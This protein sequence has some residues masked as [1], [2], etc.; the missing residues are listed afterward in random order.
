M[1]TPS[2][3]GRHP[4]EGRTHPRRQVFGHNGV[5]DGKALYRQV[6]ALKDGLSARAD[7]F[8]VAAPLLHAQ[9]AWLMHPQELSER[10]ASLTTDL[11]QLRW[12]SFHRSVGLPSPDP[13]Q[14]HADDP[15]FA[16]PVW[17]ESPTW[18]LVKVTPWINKFYVLDLHPKKSMVRYLLDQ[19]VDVFITSWKNPDESM[20]AV[21]FDDYIRDGVDAIVRVARDFSGA[22]K[23]H[24]VGY[25]IGGTALAIYMAWAARHFGE[26]AVPVRDW[27]LLTTLVDFHTPGD[28]EAF[29]DEGSVAHLTAQMQRKGYLDGKDMASS[30]RLLRSNSLVW[31]YV[32]HG[33]LYGEAPAPFDVLHWSMD[34][35]RM[36]YAMHAWYLRELYLNNRLIQPG[37]LTVAGELVPPAPR[38]TNAIP[39]LATH[40]APTCTSLEAQ[41]GAARPDSDRI[42]QPRLNHF[43]ISTGGTQN[44]HAS[45]FDHRLTEPGR[46]RVS[47]NHGQQR[48]RTA[49]GL[50]R[51]DYP[52]QAHHRGPGG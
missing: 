27:T 16:D 37:A 29:I 46:H 18:D 2:Q 17:T 52:T 13:V 34:T 1:R 19:G 25:C 12:H 42:H 49:P 21:S 5:P 8:G 4:P 10:M 32:M 45:C 50:Q 31:H 7:P 11:W 35:T 3:A 43:V 28:I 48:V 40:R 20:R 22:D 9:L 6:A 24:A 47:R 15:R 44:A 33:W 23:V 41:C 36:P 51:L 14:P 26:E 39:A 38:S 30:F